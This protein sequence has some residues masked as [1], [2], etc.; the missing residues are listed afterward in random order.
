VNE[1]QTQ[2]TEA[3]AP[4]EQT[5][6]LLL[7]NGFDE[8]LV[9]IAE[10]A[11]QKPFAVYDI[12]KCI[13]ILMKREEWSKDEALEWMSVNVVSG[14]YG[15]GTPAFMVSADKDWKIKRSPDGEPETPE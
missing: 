4:E 14:Y 13:S 1:A 3:E 7:A 5:G 8:A 9:G 6:Q 12:D 2:T 11:G 15:E 10:I